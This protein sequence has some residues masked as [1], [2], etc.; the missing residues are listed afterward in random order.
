[1]GIAT[2]PASNLLVLDIDPRHGGDESL[3][4]LELDRG[5][6]PD[7]IGAITGGGG[8]HLFFSHPG[9]HVPSRVGLR[10]GIDIRADGAYIVAT[11]SRHAS[12][13]RYQWVVA[14]GLDD[15]PLAAP[16]G[17][18]IEL[19]GDRGNTA[20]ADPS[21]S[22]VIADGQRNL[23]LARFAGAM[24]AV[25]MHE[26]EIEAALLAANQRCAPPLNETE[27]RAI[28]ASVSRYRA[29]SQRGSI[30]DRYGLLAFVPW[31]PLW[32]VWLRLPGLTPAEFKVLVAL[33]G[34]YRKAG[35]YVSL[36]QDRIA[37]EVGVGRRTAN[38][39]LL[40][41]R[42]KGF[43][44]VLPDPRYGRTVDNPTRKATL[45]YCLEPAIALVTLYAAN[46]EPAKQRMSALCD[47][48]IERL[49]GFTTS[50]RRQGWS[51]RFGALATD[52]GDAP[53]EIAAAF[54]LAYQPQPDLLK[55]SA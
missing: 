55:A 21:E 43:L 24:R 42:R 40:S 3:H 22:D 38:K 34:H 46:D 49:L 10:R 14:S 36:S 30:T 19:I 44:A 51:W 20:A 15:V 45:Y 26:A 37:H 17:W 8:R 32:S 53:N 5:P 29:E 47:A 28:A 12:S 7:S 9:G 48:G 27:V 39:Q 52:S 31:V 1:V 35:E 54:L 6:L 18:L 4:Q 23:T 16:P 41:L 50:V 11:P 33:L 25:G 13:H 2:G